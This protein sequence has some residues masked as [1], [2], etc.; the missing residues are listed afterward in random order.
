[1]TPSKMISRFAIVFL[2]VGLLSGCGGDKQAANTAN[3]DN[4]Q[5]IVTAAPTG[6]QPAGT[7]TPQS[8]DQ[9]AAT[10]LAPDSQ[11]TAATQ[12]PAESQ[13]DASASAPGE[14]HTATTE[15]SSGSQPAAAGAHQ[16]H[17]SYEGE[18]SPEHW[19]E[20]D[21]LFA[22]CEVG[23]TQSPVNIE[24]TKVQENAKLKPIEVHYKPSKVSLVNNGHTI[25]ADLQN[26][27]NHIVVEGKTYTLKQFHFHL[28]S[29][30]EVD[31]QHTD[32]ELHFVNKSDDGK[33]AV[34]GILIKQG[35]ENAELNK[36]WSHIPTEA[37]E[38]A[39]E[40]SEDFDM[41]KLLPQDLHSFRYQGSL[42][43]PPCTEGVQWIVL[44]QT[45]PW[46]KKQIDT[47]K[48]IFAHDNRPVQP[49][50][51]RKVEVDG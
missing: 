46:S 27:D 40:I 3:S 11:S 43:T 50:G 47:F 16:T 1:M 34:L 19:A 5:H 33:T 10:A 9:P 18:T 17:W 14:G 13:P 4:N 42:T 8:E 37:S 15:H 22:P 36:L 6:D 20:L 49:L 7:T 12:K 45:V 39:V 30:H 24:H 44:E 2:A 25:Q 38:E 29:E 35:T 41:N 21:E 32:M 31:G 28:P 51:D 48:A 23:K 26:A